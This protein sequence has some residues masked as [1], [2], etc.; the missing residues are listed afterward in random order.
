MQS[1]ERTEL[2]GVAGVPPSVTTAPIER[3]W[4]A[5]TDRRYRSAASAM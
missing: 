1:R 5:V 4:S 2:C 3:Q